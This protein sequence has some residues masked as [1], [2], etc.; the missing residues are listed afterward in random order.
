MIL[1]SQ[2]LSSSRKEIDLRYPQRE[3]KYHDELL[4]GRQLQ[5]DNKENGY[6]QQSKFYY[7]VERSNDLPTQ[8]LQ[9]LSISKSERIVTF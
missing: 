2:A 4:V 7:D 3:S 9:V 1:A 6:S 8:E 5:T